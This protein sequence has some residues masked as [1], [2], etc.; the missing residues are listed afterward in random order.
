MSSPGEMFA[1]I[2]TARFTGLA[3]PPPIGSN[4]IGNFM[5]ELAAAAPTELGLPNYPGASPAEGE[6]GE[7]G[8]G[9]GGAGGEGG[10]APEGDAEF[11]RAPRRPL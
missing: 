9:G 8:E 3:V 11:P 4:D 7:G 2:Y 5:T 1:E 10:G 6:G